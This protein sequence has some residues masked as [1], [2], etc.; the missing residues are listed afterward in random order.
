MGE[1]QPLAHVKR[2][3]GLSFIAL[4]C[5]SARAIRVAVDSIFMKDI[6]GEDT[7][8]FIIEAAGGAVVT[9]DGKVL[10]MMRRGMWDLPKGHRE[11]GESERECAAREVCEE[12]G[13]DPTFLTV[14]DEITRT[15]HSYVTAAGHAEEKHTVWFHIS[16]TGN[17]S[18]VSPQTE[19]EITDLEWLSPA[20][21]RHRAEKSYPTILKVI[22]KLT[23]ER[24]EKS[25]NHHGY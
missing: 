14:G 8:F 2:F 10:M 4:I 1:R 7:K 25:V 16:Y 24:Y 17:P 9:P 19:E 18:L 6:R 3:A 22:D 12:C 13:L 15:V 5:S 21:A 20:E 11:P 23:T